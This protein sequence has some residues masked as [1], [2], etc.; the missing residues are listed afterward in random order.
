VL[1]DVQPT[2]MSEL[3]TIETFE[4]NKYGVATGLSMVETIVFYH[5]LKS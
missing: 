3:H 1:E 2:V 4:V 5:K